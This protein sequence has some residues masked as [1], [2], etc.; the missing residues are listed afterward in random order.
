MRDSR[1]DIHAD[2]YS[3]GFSDQ[4]CT[5]STPFAL[6]FHVRLARV[7][8]RRI[9]GI[10][11]AACTVRHNKEIQAIFRRQFSNLRD[12]SARFLVLSVMSFIPLLPSLPRFPRFPDKPNESGIFFRLHRQYYLHSPP[13]VAE[14]AAER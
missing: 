13:T 6:P 9:S 12:K 7:L 1:F 4:S 3:F 2:C 10:P 11:N 5:E 14:H 8:D